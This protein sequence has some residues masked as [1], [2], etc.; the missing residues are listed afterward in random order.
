MRGLQLWAGSIAVHLIE[1]SFIERLGGGL[2]LPFHRAIKKVPY[3]DELGRHVPRLAV[4]ELRQRVAT[5]LGGATR[6]DRHGLTGQAT[7]TG[8]VDR[9]FAAFEVACLDAQGCAVGR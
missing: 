1:R 8:T 7:R 2:D 6:N 9:V 5:T 3:I 4:N